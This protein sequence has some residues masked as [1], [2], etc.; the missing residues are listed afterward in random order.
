[1]K[2]Y[3]RVWLEKNEGGKKSLSEAPLSGGWGR[4]KDAIGRREPRISGGPGLEGT[5][6]G[7]GP[8]LRVRKGE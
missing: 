2:G 8:D 7:K 6:G 3:G 1:V 4:Q 5:G